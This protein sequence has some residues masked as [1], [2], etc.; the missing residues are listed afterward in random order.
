MRSNR[1]QQT[2][3]TNADIESVERN[4]RYGRCILGSYAIPWPVDFKRFD[5]LNDV[6]KQSCQ[7]IT[8]QI[9]QIY[10]RYCQFIDSA[11][12]NDEKMRRTLLDSISQII[13]DRIKN[14]W[15][16]FSSFIDDE[17]RFFVHRGNILK[18]MK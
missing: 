3:M 14:S 12:Q 11:F 9:T 16:I 10:R 13:N 6:H 17:S 4:T 8:D 18:Q 2:A 7:E 5:T 1:E 15:L